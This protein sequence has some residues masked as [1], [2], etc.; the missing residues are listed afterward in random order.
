MLALIQA[1]QHI[2]ASLKR[3]FPNLTKLLKDLFP[4]GKIF[5]YGVRK[6]KLSCQKTEELYDLYSDS[7]EQLN[8]IRSNKSD[9]T[10]YFRGQ[11]QSHWEGK[12]ATVNSN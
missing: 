6:N 12:T 10:D 2:M 9:L 5:R 7:S 8:L 11:Y 3:Q 4:R 1:V